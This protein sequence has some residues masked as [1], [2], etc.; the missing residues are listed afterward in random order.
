MMNCSLLGVCFP[1]RSMSPSPKMQST[2]VQ[3][4]TQKQTQTEQTRQANPIQCFQA[5]EH[6]ILVVAEGLGNAGR[7]DMIGLLVRPSYKWSEVGMETSEC[8]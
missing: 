1:H 5:A 4:Q 8:P 7:R 3:T 6:P 2:V